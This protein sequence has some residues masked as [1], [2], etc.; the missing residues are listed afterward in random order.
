MLNGQNIYGNAVDFQT[1]CQVLINKIA[2]LLSMTLP[3]ALKWIVRRVDWAENYA[4]PFIAIQEFFEGI[5]TV[6]FPRRKASKY[7][8]HAVYFPGTPQRS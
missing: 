5:Y 8:D 3:S 6:Q 1:T 7:G 4:L 2:E